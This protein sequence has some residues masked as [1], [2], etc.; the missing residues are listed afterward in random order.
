MNKLI[1]F[2]LIGLPAAAGTI[3]TVSGTC[4]ANDGYTQSW[5]YQLSD[6]I[7]NTYTCTDP[8]AVNQ[9][10]QPMTATFTTTA[11]SSINAAVGG[12]NM[13]SAEVW[14]TDNQG[15]LFPGHGWTNVEE[16]V[17]VQEQET[18]IATGGSGQAFLDGMFGVPLD[19]G[20]LGSSSTSFGGCSGC[21]TPTEL[22]FAPIPF[23]FGQPFTLF[24]EA[25]ASHPYSIGSTNDGM[26]ALNAQVIGIVDVNG[27]PI[28]GVQFTPAETPEP[29]QL[30]GLGM[31]MLMLTSPLLKQ[32]VH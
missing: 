19:D 29:A 7:S 21:S 16:T 23:T 1:L 11:F 8:A 6:A 26:A 31:I 30:T 14:E 12:Q 25:T 17:S 9:Q 18:F 20:L 22:P 3:T 10:G 4:I 5:S 13:V 15:L 2:L 32:R 27:N 24:M 28:S